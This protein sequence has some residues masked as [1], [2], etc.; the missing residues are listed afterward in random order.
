M[1]SELLAKSPMLA[2]PLVALF[3]FIAVF[4]GVF[5]IT[6]NKRAPAYDPLARMPLDD[7][8]DV[9]HAERGASK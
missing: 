1:K 3:L 5:I 6:M 9:D 8:Q 2:L 4:V 7:D